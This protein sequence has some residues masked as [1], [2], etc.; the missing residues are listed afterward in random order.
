[1]R[2]ARESI[3]VED[4]GRTILAA[5]V[6][7]DRPPR[8]SHPPSRR[9]P[10]AGS[11]GLPQHVLAR[12][13][14]RAL[15]APARRVPC[16]LGRARRAGLVQAL[17]RASWTAC[18]TDF[19]A[20]LGVPGSEITLAPNVSTALAVVASAL[21]PHPSRR[22]RH[23]GAAGGGRG[24]GG[25]SAADARRD[26]GA[27]LSDDRPPV[28]GPRAAGRRAGDHSLVGRVDRPARRVRGGDRRAD[29]AGCHGTRL[30]HDRRAES[31]FARSPTCA[32]TAE[33]CCWSTPTR[34]RAS[35]R[36]TWWPPA[37][38]C[39]SPER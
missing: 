31:T 20:L 13:A 8:R 18:A 4:S 19:G 38:T 35:F 15:E 27:R 9:V 6:P 39:T 24:P 33:R 26:D 37:S 17:A 5:R 16:R 25:H 29:G 2:R 21:D 7:A 12:S 3:A 23:A 36:P 30:L 28:A 1:M 22:P 34:R 14:D 11:V 32:T 10:A